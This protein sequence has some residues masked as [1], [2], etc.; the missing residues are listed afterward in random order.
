MALFDIDVNTSIV[1]LTGA[2]ISA[3]SGLPTFRGDDGLWCGYR[4]EDVATPEAFKKDPDTVHDF[5][6]MRRTDLLKKEVKPNAAHKALAKL[7]KNWLGNV[8]IVTQNI[9]DLHERAG[10]KNVLHMHGELLKTKCVRCKSTFEIRENLTTADSCQRCKKT[11][12]LRPDIVWFGEMPYFMGDILNRLETCGLFIAIGTSGH[13]YP[14]AGFV[15][16][17][18]F[19]GAK[20]A[21]LNLEPS[22]NNAAFHE[23]INGPA[24]K[25]VPAF[26]EKLLDLTRNF[27]IL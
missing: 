19:S 23:S 3:E 5:Y 1:I 12:S 24:S 27:S 4:I 25:T 8:T 16:E 14:A 20:T 11:G 6:N 15:S 9:D 13:V 2:G 7:E 18:L 22:A 17:A 21:E 10:S 26:V